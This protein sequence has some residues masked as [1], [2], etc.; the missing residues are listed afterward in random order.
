MI[1]SSTNALILTMDGEFTIHR[2][3]GVAITGDSIVAVGPDALAFDAA[4]TLD[5]GGRVVMPGL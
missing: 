3:G 5:C 2:S 4:A 1:S